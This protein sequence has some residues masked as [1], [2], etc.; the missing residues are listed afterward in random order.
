MSCASAPSRADGS[1]ARQRSPCTNTQEREDYEG[2]TVKAVRAGIEAIASATDEDLE[3][4][5]EVATDSARRDIIG[6][7]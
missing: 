6:K 1:R 4:L 7:E 3:E 2:W 5:L